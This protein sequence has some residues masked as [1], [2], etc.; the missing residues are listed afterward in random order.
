MPTSPQPDLRGEPQASRRILQVFNRYLMPGGEENSVARIAAHLELA[1]HQVTRF[2]RASEEWTRPDAPAKWRQLFRTLNNPPVLRELRELHLRTKPDFW[3]LH[4]VVPVIS[5]GVYRLARELGVPVIQWLHNY[6]PVSPS[7]TLRAGQETLAPDDPLLVWKEILAGSWRGRLPTAWLANGYAQLRRSGDLE[8]VKAW[9]AVSADMKNTFER[10][11]FPAEKIHLLRHSWDIQPPLRPDSNDGYF[12]FLGRMVEEK[13]VKFLIELWARPEFK[14]V[15]LV[16]AGQG[17]LADFYRDRTPPN[18]RWAGFVRGEEKRRLVAGSRAVL[19]PCLWN[20]PLT[21]VVYEAFEQ[22]RPVLASD[23][24]GLKDL[25]T[26]GS[27]GRLL[28]PGNPAA[29][30]EV[31]QQFI[32]EPEAGRAM[33]KR[34][35]EW[36]NAN[37]SPRVWGE[38]FNAIAHQIVR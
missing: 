2:R 1:G 28:A 7:G 34:G 13:G 33:G 6:R 18:I 35:L 26:D 16:M 32:R 38:Q 23:L 24:G 19:F 3:I 21:T 27:T 12:L 10:G 37:V 36:L 14:D 15:P 22:A 17:P 8:S 4:N 29:W 25:I 31:L 20:E 5:L 11:G 30:S 9:I